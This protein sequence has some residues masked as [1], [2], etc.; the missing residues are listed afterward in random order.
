[1]THQSFSGKTW[2]LDSTWKTTSKL[3]SREIRINLYNELRAR[4]AERWVRSAVEPSS[5]R[6]ILTGEGTRRGAPPPLLVHGP[7][8]HLFHP[9][10][11]TFP[12]LQAR[13]CAESAQ[14]LNSTASLSNIFASLPSSILFGPMVWWCRLYITVLLEEILTGSSKRRATLRKGLYL[15]V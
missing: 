13:R 6:T 7:P 3:H 15:E 1:M 12:P 10:P 14:H 8:I 5:A 11:S 2:N 4:K 9:S